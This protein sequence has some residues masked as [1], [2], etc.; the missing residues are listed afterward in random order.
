MSHEMGSGS[1]QTEPGRCGEQL[2][3][4]GNNVWYAEEMRLRRPNQGAALTKKKE[5]TARLW[6][7]AYLVGSRYQ[8]DLVAGRWDIP[9]N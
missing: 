6:G 4:T 9:R 2:G 5:A 7:Y 8:Q 3:T 1:L